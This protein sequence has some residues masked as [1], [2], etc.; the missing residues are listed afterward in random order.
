[1]GPLKGEQAV[2]TTVQQIN[3]AV[4]AA[5][6]DVEA[7]PVFG[8]DRH[9]LTLFL[10][11]EP[12][13]LSEVARGLADRGWINVADPE[14]GCLYPKISVSKDVEAVM[15]RLTEACGL[16]LDHGIEITG[17]DADTSPLV[18]RAAFVSLFQ[19]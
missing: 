2:L 11:G 6:T 4:R 13:R 18:D 1:M 5:Y 10:I 16:A 19:G 14:M 3:A 15:N 9:W 7:S 8:A 12:G 17:I